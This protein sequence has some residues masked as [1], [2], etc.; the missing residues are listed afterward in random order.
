MHNESPTTRNEPR[1]APDWAHCYS[2]WRPTRYHVKDSSGRNYGLF[3]SHEKASLFANGVLGCMEDDGAYTCIQTVRD[4]NF[5]VWDGDSIGCSRDSPAIVMLHNDFG[6]QSMRSVREVLAMPHMIDAYGLG[7]IVS[8]LHLLA[9]VG[10]LHPDDLAAWREV[11][12]EFPIAR[13][14]KVPPSSKCRA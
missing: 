9:N 14:L 2:E 1:R 6:S 13:M 12:G 4:G 8:A 5:F 11:E 3:T 10:D 7:R